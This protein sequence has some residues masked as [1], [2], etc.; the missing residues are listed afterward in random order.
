MASGLARNSAL[1]ALAGIAVTF[2]NFASSVIIARLLGVEG[3]G[4]VA[5]LV[6]IALF[7]V[8]VLDLGLAASAGRYLP[9]LRARG[10]GDRAERLAARLAQIVLL[11]AGLAALALAI[12]AVAPTLEAALDAGWSGD[13]GAGTWLALAALIAAQTTGNYGYLYLRGMQWFARSARIAIASV[14]AQIVVVCA[15]AV[16]LGPTGALAGYV[17]GQALPAIVALRCA[18]R[19]APGSGIGHETAR[20]VRRYAFFA[21]TAG[22]ANAFVWSRIE[23]FFLERAWGAQEVGLFTVAMALASLAVQAPVMLTTAALPHLAE[24]RGREDFGA[25]CRS[26]QTGTRLLALLVFPACVGTAAIMPVLLPLIFGAAFSAAVPAAILLVLAAAIGATSVMMT[27]LVLAMDRND[28]V[29]VCALVGAGFAVL[30][31]LLLVPSFGVMGAAI[32]RAAIQILLV[33]AGIWFVVA[34]LGCAYP[35][36][37]VLRLLAAATVTALPALCAIL[38][39][40]PD[41]R[42]L[43]VSIPLGIAIYVPALRW[44]RAVGAADRAILEELADHLPMNFRGWA[45]RLVAYIGGRHAYRT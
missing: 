9:E 4:A 22:I 20:R 12:I 16:L 45:W 27:N 37:G 19:V 35:F 32:S 24:Q 41:A 34:R 2:G 21:W 38:I 14:A 5:F 43:F 25:M 7:L 40:G 10:E 29:L 30:A 28:F 23:I 17:A 18:A 36:E 1:G 6:W 39:I 44:T 3:T 33:G 31:G 11:P 8:P 15:G 26:C 42:T 13:A